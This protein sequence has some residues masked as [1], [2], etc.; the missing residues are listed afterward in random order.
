MLRLLLSCAVLSWAS[1]ALGQQKPMYTI[2]ISKAFTPEREQQYAAWVQSQIPNTQVLNAYPDKEDK[3]KLDQYLNQADLVI[4]SGGEDVDPNRYGKQD[5][6]PLCGKIDASRDSLEFYLVEQSLK[7]GKPLLGICRGM[8]LLNVQQGGT[9]VADIPTKLTNPLAHRGEPT[10]PSHHF[11]EVTAHAALNPT[12]KAKKIEVNSYH[13]QCV[14]AL[15]PGWHITATSPDGVAEA[16]EPNTGKFPAW[17]MGVQWHPERSPEHQLSKR[18]I[19]LMVQAMS[20][21]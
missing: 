10:G 5:L 13:H 2:L 20:K 14:D 4:I 12:E 21:R 8:Q 7:L 18:L 6:L 16:M 3:A 11:I 1:L 17:V 19:E 15:A 9:L